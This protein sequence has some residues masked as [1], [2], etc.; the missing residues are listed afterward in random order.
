MIDYAMSTRQ[1]NIRIAKAKLAKEIKNLDR[2]ISEIVEA[3]TASA[4]I[5]A[6][7]GSKSYTRIDLPKLEALRANLSRRYG[8]LVR[9]LQGVG[10]AGI[11]HVMTV[12]S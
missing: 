1:E 11:R 8:Q 3:G 12:R 6:A 7:G 9:S 4:T 5:S 10:P 2:V